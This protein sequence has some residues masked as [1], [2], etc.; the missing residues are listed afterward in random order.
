MLPTLQTPVEDRVATRETAVRFGGRGSA[1]V[2]RVWVP[3]QDWVAR[4]TQSEGRITVLCGWCVEPGCRYEYAFHWLE[5]LAKGLSARGYTV[6]FDTPRVEG[7]LKRY[8]EAE[9]TGPT[10]LLVFVGHFED[11]PGQDAK[12]RS[13]VVALPQT[14]CTRGMPS[15]P[16]VYV[17]RG[18]LEKWALP[19]KRVLVWVTCHA[20]RMRDA[21]AAG[22]A[23]PF[24]SLD[25]QTIE[26]PQAMY[27]VTRFID[28]F[29][30]GSL[31]RR[32]PLHKAHDRALSDL[33]RMM[34]LMRPDVTRPPVPKLRRLPFTG[35][36]YRTQ[37]RLVSPIFGLIRTPWMKKSLWWGFLLLVAAAVVQ[38]LSAL[39]LGAELTR[40]QVFRNTGEQQYVLP[41]KIPVTLASTDVI[42]VGPELDRTD[43]LLGWTCLSVDLA[44]LG[45][46]PSS[47][48]ECKVT[49][50]L[51][52]RPLRV[53]LTT[54]KG[55]SP[56]A[57]VLRVTLTAKPLLPRIWP[58]PPFRVRTDSETTFVDLR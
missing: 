33:E 46:Q 17:Q 20:D 50:L 52:P 24:V 32:R 6:E 15:P 21:V 51:V 34:R 5:T 45:D 54:V 40:V 58:F 25:D 48:E 18:V 44:V 27:Y 11:P 1:F 36:F 28:H 2:R 53:D 55:L 26:V 57:Y 47:T 39:T 16:P 38:M 8:L 42:H 35:L 19:K 56:G 43:S 29:V 10:D 13:N 22:N 14:P 49:S 4:R 12:A 37:P 23:P 9:V 30:H 7:K 31:L 3:L 41:T